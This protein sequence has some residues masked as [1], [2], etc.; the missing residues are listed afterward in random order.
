[1]AYAGLGRPL[2]QEDGQLK[3]G[4]VPAQQAVELAARDMKRGD[5]GVFA[6]EDVLRG[7]SLAEFRDRLI[8]IGAQLHEAGNALDVHRVRVCGVAPWTCRQVER[9]GMNLHVDAINDL[10][11]GRA[12]RPIAPITQLAWILVLCVGVAWQRIRTRDAAPWRQRVI[13]AG[14]VVADLILVAAAAI[15]LELL[16]DEL[17]HVLAMLSAYLIVSRLDKH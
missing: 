9:W 4:D 10:L 13:F 2:E 16:M 17:Y 12:I 3:P 1:V 6:F 14:L 8:V 15:Y 5:V 11:R 7:A